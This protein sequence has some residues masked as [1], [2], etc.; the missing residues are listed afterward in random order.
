VTA[1]I[2]SGTVSRHRSMVLRRMCPLCG[3]PIGSSKLELD[4]LME[5][6]GRACQTLAGG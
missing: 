3:R 2:T 4:I 6:L 1:V 5:T